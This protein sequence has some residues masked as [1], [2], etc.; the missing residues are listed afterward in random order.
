MFGS[1]GDL[2]AGAFAGLT[3]KAPRDMTPEEIDGLKDEYRK[4]M[5]EVNPHGLSNVSLRDLAS[6][7]QSAAFVNANPARINRG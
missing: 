7:A 4:R 1:F 5:D 6:D 2:A 3:T